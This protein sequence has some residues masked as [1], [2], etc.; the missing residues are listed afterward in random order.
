MVAQIAKLLR[1][2]LTALGSGVL[3][4]SDDTVTQIASGLVTLAPYVYSAI[5][6]ILAARAA[7]PAKVGGTD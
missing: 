5:K 4:T 2:A 1:Y 6:D 7:V 3:I